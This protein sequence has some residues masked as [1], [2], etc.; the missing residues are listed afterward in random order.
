MGG[1]SSSIGPFSGINSGQLIEQLLSIEARPI[2]IAQGRL[3]QLQLQQTAILD[4][5]SRLSTLR[6]AASAFRTNKT[7]N[8]TKA[9]SSDETVL[10]ATSSTTA[11][12]GTYQFIVDRLVSTQ[13]LLSRGFA[14]KSS[15]GVGATEFSFETSDARLDR[16]VSL[17]DLNGGSGVAR[18]KIVLTEGSKSVTVDLSKAA[19]VSEVLDAING[20]GV[21]DVKATVKDGKIIL[22]QA[23]GAAFSVSNASGYTT[24]ESL[25]ISGSSGVGGVLTGTSVYGLGEATSLSALNDGN[26]VGI[27]SVTGSGAFNLNVKVTIAGV[28][29]D[30]KVNLGEVYAT[31]G[32]KQVLKETTVSTVGGVIKRINEAMSAAGKS[33]VTAGI[34]ADGTKLE[35]SDSSNTVT[36]LQFSDNPTLHDGTA[37]AL[38]LTSGAFGGHAYTSGRIFAGLNTTLASKLNGGKGISGD[39][40]IDITARDGTSFTANIDLDGTLAQ[41][42]ADIEAASGTGSNGK[43]R[44]SVGV[45]EKG[46]GLVVTDNTGSTSSKLIITGTTDVDSALSLGISTGAA[47]VASSTVT[48]TNLQHAYV[49]RATLVGDLNG[50]KGLGTGKFRLTDSFGATVVIDIADDTKNIG[51]LIDEMNSQAS[52]RGLKLQARINDNGDGI[53]VEEQVGSGP[54]GTLKIKI[55]DETGSVATALHI[56]GEASGVNADNKINGSQERTVKFSAS[57]TLEAIAKKINEANAGMTASIIKDGSGSSPYRLALSSTVAGRDGRVLIDTGA[58]SLGLTTMEKGEDSRVFF[59]ASDPAKAVL[60]TSSTNSLDGVVSGVTIDLKATSTAPVSLSVTTDSSGIESEVQDFVKAFNDIIGRIDQQQSYNADT[61]AKGPLLGDGS[62]NALRVALYNAIQA[63]TQNVTGRYKRLA[64]VGVTVGA[65]GNLQLDTDKF[66]K[67]LSEDPKSVE[68]LFTARVVDGSAGT[69]DLGNGITAVDPNASAKY[70][71]LGVLG[72]VEELSKRYIDATSGLW[73]AKK[74]ATDTL[75]TTQNSRITDMNERLDARR[76]ILQSQFQRMETA[77]AKLQQQ[78]S[79]LGSLG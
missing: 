76:G 58:T 6:D 66:R 51:Q 32:G 20:N 74:K 67:A 42:A 1:I 52:G 34:S 14:D 64:E 3:A 27:T 28:T 31:E 38:G 79:A 69:I 21:V 44:I 7:F 25:G 8:M 19:T 77:I 23:A 2:K 9:S 36:D 12:A 55:A 65:G 47:G 5:N 43:P 15:T 61:R 46:T 62:T 70:S 17:S 63:P 10:K 26:G 33:F 56:A 54:S 30:V 40:V 68:S 57:D 24:A 48:S 53:V 71:S 4:I 13:Q 60:L 41:I 59:G 45:N 22:K 29:S 18:G 16:D 78:Q 73:T 49:S 75:I 50:G 35:I 37:A 39:G 72:Q 11:Q